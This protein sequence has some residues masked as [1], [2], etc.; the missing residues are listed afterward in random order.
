MFCCYAFRYSVKNIMTFSSRPQIECSLLPFFV[1]F[2][3][4]EFCSKDWETRLRFQLRLP[5]QWQYF[6]YFRCL[7]GRRQITVRLG[8]MHEQ[9]CLQIC[10]GLPQPHDPSTL[11]ASLCISDNVAIV[12]LTH[13]YIHIHSLLC[14][15]K[16]AMCYASVLPAAAT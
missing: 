7:F 4:C 10:V 5:F 13:T 8:R 11:W 14:R 3:C 1:T 15:L 9:E 6:V 16:Y 2:F 12:S